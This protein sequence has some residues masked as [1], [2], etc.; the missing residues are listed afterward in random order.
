M[1]VSSGKRECQCWPTI[2]RGVALF[3]NFN[4]TAQT[5]DASFI[6]WIFEKNLPQEFIVGKKQ[7]M[8][9]IHM[10]DRICS[11]SYA[12]ATQFDD[13][14]NSLVMGGFV[15]DNS[16][17]CNKEVCQKRSAATCSESESLKRLDLKR[18]SLK[19]N[20]LKRKIHRL[21]RHSRERQ[22]LKRYSLLKDIV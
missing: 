2:Y 15:N 5:S 1:V 7:N 6:C 18:P 16:F 4:K 17:G 10:D 12:L 13:A 21:K 9:S 20:D 8:K 3:K 14:H 22:N 19:R 11:L